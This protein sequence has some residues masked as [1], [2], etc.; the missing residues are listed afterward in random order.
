[1]TDKPMLFSA[2]MIRA[3]LDG[4]KHQTR[5]KLPDTHPKF[6]DHCYM[7]LDVLSDPQEVWY[8]DGVHERVG[9]SYRVPY[10][11]GDRLFPAMPIPSLNRNYCADVHRCNIDAMPT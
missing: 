4:R 6:P 2:P 8:W 11:P 10:A 1:M 7:S 3:L 9:S 5:R